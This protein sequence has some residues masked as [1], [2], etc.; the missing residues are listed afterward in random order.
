[1]A[2]VKRDNVRENRIIDEI[3]VD[4]HDVEEQALSW[5]YYL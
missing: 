2:K 5:Y 3:I 4:A 1:M